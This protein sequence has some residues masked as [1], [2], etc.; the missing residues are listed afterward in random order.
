MHR[1]R[2][3]SAS[4]FLVHQ[5]KMKF[6]AS[7]YIYK[8][9]LTNIACACF[10]HS[11]RSIF[12]ARWKAGAFFL[13]FSIVSL[14][15]YESPVSALSLLCPLMPMGMIWRLATLSWIAYQ[16]VIAFSGITLAVWSAVGGIMLRT[17]AHYRAWEDRKHSESRGWI[18]FGVNV[19][20]KCIWMQCMHGNK[21]FICQAGSRPAKPRAPLTSCQSTR[22]CSQQSFHLCAGTLLLCIYLRR[23]EKDLL[24]LHVACSNLLS[25]LS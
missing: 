23:R 3:I 18:L 13:L 4:L 10:T 24:L 17:M 7:L 2:V 25:L 1:A 15:V 6:P 12:R 19:R 20:L 22:L 16:G 8:Y 9:W 14:I 11:V 5:L 21:A